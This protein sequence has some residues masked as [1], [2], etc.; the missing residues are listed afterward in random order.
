M[1]NSNYDTS[2]VKKTCEKKLE[3]E[4]RDGKEFN[5]WF[6]LEGRKDKRITVPKG[7]KPIPRKTYGS[8]ARQLGLNVAEFDN[9]LACP[10]KIAGYI[11]IL[12]KKR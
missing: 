5:G 3:I 8:M 11:E 10:L 12:R 6:Y 9:L 1:K 7:R 2:D 4:F